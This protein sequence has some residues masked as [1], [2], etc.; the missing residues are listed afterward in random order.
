[1]NKKPPKKVKGK[2]NARNCKNSFGLQTVPSWWDVFD[3]VPHHRAKVFWAV[4]MQRIQS[5]TG[6]QSKAVPLAKSVGATVMP[7]P[8][9]SGQTMP[10]WAGM[11]CPKVSPHRFNRLPATQ[12]DSAALG[13]FCA[14]RLCLPVGVT[15]HVPAC[16]VRKHMKTCLLKH[17]C[18]KKAEQNLGMQCIRN[19][20]GQFTTMRPISKHLEYNPAGIARIAAMKWFFERGILFVIFCLWPSSYAGSS[21]QVLSSTSRWADEGQKRFFSQLEFSDRI[22]CNAF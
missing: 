11:N 20:H 13:W 12:P 9:Q 22:L 18:L 16:M 17:H 8:Q 7:V 3:I 6:L 1:M 19:C 4:G 21:L 5:K 15:A 10:E 14:K 2:Q